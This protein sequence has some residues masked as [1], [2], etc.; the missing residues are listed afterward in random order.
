M[1]SATGGG[2]LHRSHVVAAALVETRTAP[3][4]LP[5]RSRIIRD[6]AEGQKGDHREENH[7]GLFSVRVRQ[8][9]AGDGVVGMLRKCHGAFRR[10]PRDGK[11]TT[12][13]RLPAEGGQPRI[14]L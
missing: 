13:G 14:R 8:E 10:D 5:D 7:L 6:G 11:T 12:L 3:E 2:G 9:L 1:L 4:S